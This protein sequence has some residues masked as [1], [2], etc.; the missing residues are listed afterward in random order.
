MRLNENRRLACIVLVVCIIG[1]IVGLGGGS[2][3]R[4]RNHLL[5]IFYNGTDKKAT[6]RY[7][8]DAYLDRAA[9]CAQVMASE[10]QLYLGNDYAAAMNMLSA[11]DRFDDEDGLDARYGAYTD[12]Q[13]DSDLLYNA[14]YA[15]KLTDAERVNFKRAYDDFWG[16]DKYIRKDE[17]RDEAADFNR[18]LKGF[19]ASAVAALMGVDELNSFGA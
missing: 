19:P 11:L 17:Y 7:S 8:M 15:L 13:R 4:E 1:S 5:N 10:A 3:V 9:D 6:A 16:C 2:L 12:I 14:M 18:T